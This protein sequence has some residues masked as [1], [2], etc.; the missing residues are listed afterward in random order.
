MDVDKAILANAAFVG[1]MV[2]NP[3]IFMNTDLADLPEDSELDHRNGEHV[4]QEPSLGKCVGLSLDCG[5]TL[6]L[7]APLHSPSHSMSL[8]HDHSNLHDHAAPSPVARDA[9]HQPSD[10]STRFRRR[11]RPTDFDIDKLRSTIKQFVR[12]WSHEVCI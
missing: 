5:L 2:A 11:Y 10:R 12:D 7:G 6:V 8:S 9:S 1:Q 3:E 4:R